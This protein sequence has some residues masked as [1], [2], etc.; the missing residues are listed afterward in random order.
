MRSLAKGLIPVYEEH[1][2]RISNSMSL[3]EW[4]ELPYM[5]RAIIVAMYRIKNSIGNLKAE[6][7]IR[8]SDAKAKGHK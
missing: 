2:A 3:N 6:A 4:D 1:S 5:E 7:E 8:E